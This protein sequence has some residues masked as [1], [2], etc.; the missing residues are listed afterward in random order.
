MHHRIRIVRKALGFN[1]IDFARQIGLTQTS[2]SMLEMANNAITGKNIK[3]ICMTFNVNEEWLRT[4]KGE[5]FNASPYVKELGDILTRLTPDTQQY[6]LL[7]AREL[8][9]LQQ[10]LLDGPDVIL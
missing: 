8:L 9:N 7:M 6:L 4:G 2:L 5:M 1:Q 10:K 3:L